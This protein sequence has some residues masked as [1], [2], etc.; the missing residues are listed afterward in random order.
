M[1]ERPRLLF[2]CQTLPYPLDGGVWIRSYH[3]MRLL[4]RAFDVTALC[5]ER[6]GAS[7]ARGE[8]DV[9]SSVAELSRFAEVEAFELAQ[10][11]SRPR[12]VWNHLRSLLSRR[13]YTRFMYESDAFRERLALALEQ[14]GADLVHADSLDLSAY[15]PTFAHLPTVCVHHNIESELLRRRSRFDGGPLRSRYYEL[16]ADWMRRE[17]ET[18][19]PRVSLNVMVSETDRDTLREIAPT[20]RTTVVPNGVDVEEFTPEPGLEQGVVYVGGTNWFPN[21]DA[22]DFFCEDVLPR[23]EGVEGAHPVRWVGSATPEEQARYRERFGVELTGYVDDVRPFMRDAMCHVVPLR[24]GGGTRLKILNSWAMGK[25]VVSTSIGC[26][27]LDAVDGENILVRDDP[28]EFAEAVRRLADDPDLRRRLGENARRTAVET[29]SWDVVGREM[30][31]TYL[32]LLEPGVTAGSG[33]TS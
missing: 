23:L 15:L 11:T 4:S 18:W 22:L 30:V 9:A 16:Q 31:R 14:S 13:V 29:Y 25:P 27:G 20:A 1:S 7:G 21:L 6:S 26:E 5:F 2:L 33:P 8:Y 17:E 24:V 28:V 19:T 10:N 3:V 12:Y 32:E